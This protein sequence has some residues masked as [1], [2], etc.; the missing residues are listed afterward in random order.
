MKYRSLTKDEI[1]ALQQQG[2][3]C[4]EWERIA[5]APDFNA[6]R[7]RNVEFS[8]DIRLGTFSGE[9]RN[10]AGFTTP[11]GLYDARIHNCTVGDNCLIHRVHN[12]IANYTL[13]NDV[14]IENVDSIYVDGA[15]CFGNGTRVNVLNEKGGRAIRIFNGLSAQFAYFQV[16]YRH[17]TAVIETLER[18]GEGEIA[19][20]CR[21]RGVIGDHARI[22]SCRS[23]I[24]VAV[25][26]SA[27]ITGSERLQNGSVNSRAGAPVEIGTAVIADNFIINGN[28]R[29]LDGS[30]ISNCFIGEGAEL[31]KQYS[32]EHSLFFA[33]FIGHHGEAFAVFAAPFTAT[34]HRSTLLISAYLSFMNAGSGSNQSNHAYKLGPIHQGILGRGSKTASD[35]YILWP[36]RIGDFTLIIGRHNSHCDTRYL[37]YTY[38]IEGEKARTFAIP[39]VNLKSVGTIRDADKWPVRDRRTGPRRDIINFDLLT[40]SSVGSMLRGRT[41]LKDLKKNESPE[42]GA[43]HYK[44]TFIPEKALDKGIYYYEIGILKYLGNI[45]V[46]RLRRSRP[47]EKSDLR[48][49]LTPTGDVGTG[50]W[51]DIGGLIAPKSEVDAVLKKLVEEHSEHGE[52]LTERLNAVH[53]RYHEYSW[54]W[55]CRAFREYM[56]KSPEEMTLNEIKKIL[57]KWIN[58]TVKLDDYFIDDAAK[59]FND[60]ARVGFGIDECNGCC[61]EDFTAV[62]GSIDSNG[63]VLR[64]NRHKE[65][66]KHQYYEVMERLKHLG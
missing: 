52:E 62:R 29:L 56:G 46:K 42:N 41:V 9:F 7:C 44:G 36:A 48:T 54:N 12:Y 57:E 4:Q 58:V 37:P 39:G 16:F 17:D 55:C 30:I 8:G 26:E 63:F 65:S 51:V 10:R 27:R 15:T 66:K 3:R 20:T 22:V 64:I 25:G 5:V 19:G 45:L 50:D 59:E 11:A 28:A 38:L 53:A 32:A 40:P 14:L 18:I 49:I 47:T 13:G 60:Q 21:E 61:E 33:N 1:A 31:A 23:I 35:S 2:C 34:H 43:Y 6:G 24:N